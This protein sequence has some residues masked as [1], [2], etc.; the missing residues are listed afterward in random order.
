MTRTTST[1]PRWAIVILLGAIVLEGLSFRT[2][3]TEARN[4]SAATRRWWQFIRRAKNPELPVVLLEDF[5]ALIGLSIALVARRALAD[6][7]GNARWDAAGT[8]RHRH[9]ARRA[10]PSSSRSRCSSLLLGESATTPTCGSAIAQ[11][12]R[13]RRPR[14]AG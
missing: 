12:D 10:S 5:A 13:R 8:P 4:R 14:C 11:R 7:T 1:R 3:V 9:A 2:A 6:A